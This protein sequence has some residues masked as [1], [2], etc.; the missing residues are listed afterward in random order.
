MMSER[1]LEIVSKIIIRLIGTLIAEI[2][3]LLAI[4][5]TDIYIIPKISIFTANSIYT[6]FFIVSIAIII[7]A[8]I[9][10]LLDIRKINKKKKKGNKK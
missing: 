5:I 4:G 8:T 1:E 9:H 2:L 3:L 6:A 7:S 10:I